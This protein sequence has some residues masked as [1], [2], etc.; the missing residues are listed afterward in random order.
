WTSGGAFHRFDNLLRGIVEIVGGGDIETGLGDD[1][2]AEFDIG[3]LKPHD[4]RHLEPDF[5]HRSDDPF[6]DDVAFHDAAENID[7]DAL[8]VRV[9]SDDLEGGG[10]LFL[11]SPAADVEEVGRRHAVK[12]DD[13]HGRHGKAGTVDHAAD[14]AVEGDVIQVVFRRLDLLLIFLGQIAQRD[15]V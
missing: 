7:E 11:R 10:N 6:G 1:L 15:D 12:L 4:E 2:L 8:H 5:L 14:R 3:A 13:V 9:G